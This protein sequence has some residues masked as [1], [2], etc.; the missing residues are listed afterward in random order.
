MHR[1]LV[2]IVPALVA[3]GVLAPAAP[4]SSPAR[5]VLVT[6]DRGQRLAAFDGRM[7]AVSGAE[8]MQMRFVLQ[9]RLP[10]HRHYHRVR[11]PGFSAWQT[12]EAGKTRYVY[13]KR[14]DG[15]V[16]P[17]RYR[18]VVRFRWLD[19]DGDVVREA[20]ARS[21]SCRQPDPRPDLSVDAIDVRPGTTPDRRRY[22]VTIANTGRSDADASKLTLDLGDGGSLFT[23]SVD[24]IG[25]GE[26]RTVVI[27]GRACLP[28]AEL[29]ATA[30]AT[31]VIDERDE[32]DN[33]LAAP[34][35]G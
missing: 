33:V 20:R 35:P 21:R 25:A 18:V 27:G 29:T 2:T 8:R 11:I 28:G 4:A 32:D 19:Q 16:G 15:L 31:D 3:A 1:A 14:V 10:H 23:T 13:T 22:A 9:D 26:Q 30:D 5:A 17:A 7:D 12:S 6:C 24:P 34:C